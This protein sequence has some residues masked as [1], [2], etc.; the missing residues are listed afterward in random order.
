MSEIKDTDSKYARVTLFDTLGRRIL[1]YVPSGLFRISRGVIFRKDLDSPDL[2]EIANRPGE[3]Q[4]RSPEPD[5]RAA[6]RELS[7]L[8]MTEFDR[9]LKAGNQCLVVFEDGS[10]QNINWIHYGPAYIRGFAYLHE[11]D[12]DEAYV[13][14]II[15]APAQRGK[16]IY[17]KALVEMDK[18]IVGQRKKTIIQL[19]ESG[20]V[21]VFKTLPKRGFYKERELFHIT[22]FGIKITRQKYL[23]DGRRKTKISVRQPENVFII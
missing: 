12:D 10:P 1:R 16:G 20:N 5:E 13:Y 4:L 7:G 8:S 22:L 11:A 19:V 17:K 15:T 3:I 23:T 6:C 2:T 18:I 14:G 21:P 9:R